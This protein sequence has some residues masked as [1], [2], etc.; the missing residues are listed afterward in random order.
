MGKITKNYI[1]NFAYQILVLLAP[2]VTAP[3][4][5]KTLGAEQIG[6]FTYVHTVTNLVCT[7]SIMG[8]QTYGNREIAYIR[9]DSKKVSDKFSDIIGTR[10]LLFIVATISYIIVSICLK[11]YRMYF[12]IY[13]IYLVARFLDCTWLY[14]G[15]EDMKWV[16]IK[17]ALA[18]I[19]LIIS[20]FVFIYTPEDLWK[21]IW[22]QGVSLLLANILSYTQ[23]KR[24]I[25]KFKISFKN[26]KKII[27]QTFLLFLP[28]MAT[29]IYV[30]CD[31]IM[32]EIFTGN[33]SQIAFYD[34]SEKIIL[35]PLSFITVLSSVMMPRLAN[36]FSKGN[37]EQISVL[38]N[39]SVRVSMF[40]A[41]PLIF[42]FLSIS[43]KMIPWYLGDEFLP[44]ILGINIMLPIVL[45]NT[46]SSILG[47][48][49]LV[50]TNQPNILIKSQTLASVLNIITN[51]ILIP[52][53]GFYGAT[54][55]TVVS[56]FTCVCIQFIY[57]K[58]QIKFDN[59]LSNSVKYLFYSVI[60][61]L[62]IRITT[63]NFEA[64]VITTLIQIL[65]GMIVFFAIC[66]I[67]KDKQILELLSIFKRFKKKE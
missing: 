11:E 25:L 40:L 14:M 63:V 50:A 13:Y 2:L 29:T 8:S 39:K 10:I 45:L 19:F 67:F 64:N 37:L 59:L 66:I 31:K 15:V 7:F 17:N 62:V 20:I 38:L 34:Y 26:V 65:L 21:Y 16:A 61:F 12:A 48:Q 42:G 6:V 55:A 47:T 56:S 1:Y 22:I 36:E 24:H 49:Y 23:I 60:M 30:E 5:A 4:L 32:I 51:I 43:D 52:K 27:P 9:D 35:I 18:K 33:S 57:V 58:K 3:Y 54:I 53:F 46:F 28:T 41:F 44:V